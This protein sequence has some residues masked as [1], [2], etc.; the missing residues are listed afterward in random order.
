MRPPRPAATATAAVL[1]ALVGA[2]C[3]T[4]RDAAPTAE[5]A[6]KRGPLKVAAVDG[7]VGDATTASSETGLRRLSVRRGAIR[8]GAVREGVDAGAACPDAELMPSA[9]NLAAVAAATMCLVNGERADAGLPALS[10]SA[11]LDQSSAGHSQDM[12][13]H[14]YFAHQSHDGRDL[15]ARVRAAGY[16][17]DHASWTVGENLAWGTGTLATPRA[18]VEAWM[19]SQGHRENIHRA[20]FKE[21]GLGI[22]IG[23]PQAANGE[24]ATYTMNFGATSSPS[25]D[26]AST[27]NAVVDAATTATTRVTTTARSSAARRLRACRS[28]A[29]RAKVSRVRKARLARCARVARVARRARR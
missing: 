3:G 1:L 18:I 12:V 7:R 27:V 2:G 26:I 11:R 24:G 29:R 10:A 20:A 19:N 8:P 5:P 4:S 17:P 9:G 25:Q 21:A 6:A 23:N 14:S 28:R 15:V 16:I 13:D 22:V